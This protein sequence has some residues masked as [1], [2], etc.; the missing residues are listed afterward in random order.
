MPFMHQEKWIFKLP[1]LISYMYLNIYYTHKIYMLLCKC[2]RMYKI[3]A[4][5]T[6]YTLLK[7]KISKPTSFQSPEYNSEQKNKTIFT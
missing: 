7:T 5:S 3:H 6:I 4:R 1:A 2:F